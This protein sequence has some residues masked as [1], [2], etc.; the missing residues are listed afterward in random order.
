MELPTSTIN[1]SPSTAEVLFSV[2]GCISGLISAVYISYALLGSR[3]FCNPT[4]ILAVPEVYWLNSPS[5]RP[6][7]FQRFAYSVSTESGLGWPGQTLKWL[8]GP[9]PWAEPHGAEPM[10]AEKTKRKMRQYFR[11]PASIRHQ[12]ASFGCEIVQLR[13]RWGARHRI[14]PAD[15]ECRCSCSPGS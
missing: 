12:S 8:E 11:I 3:Y 7:S 5:V 2:D 6:V 13:P 4:L 9:M 1:L 10:A 14:W 15:S